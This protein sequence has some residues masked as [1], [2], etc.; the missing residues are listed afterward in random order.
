MGSSGFEW[1]FSN[2]V[3]NG[4]QGLYNV[5]FELLVVPPFV[6]IDDGE[7]NL[8]GFLEEWD[9]VLLGCHGD[10]GDCVKNRGFD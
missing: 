10:G 3:S 7:Q 1:L 2:G 6:S 8:G 9:K 5:P 4:C